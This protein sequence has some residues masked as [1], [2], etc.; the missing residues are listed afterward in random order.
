MNLS[1]ISKVFKSEFE[2]SKAEK[3]NFIRIIKIIGTEAKRKFK[4]KLVVYKLNLLSLEFHCKSFLLKVNE[5]NSD[6]NCFVL[7]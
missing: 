3:L 7:V 1:R 4:W 6:L 2:L 5:N